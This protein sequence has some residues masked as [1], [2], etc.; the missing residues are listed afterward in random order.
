MKGRAHRFLKSFQHHTS[1]N[2]NRYPKYRLSP[3]AA[4]HAKTIQIL[5]IDN[6]WLAPKNPNYSKTFYVGSKVEL[7]S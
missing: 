6:S 7:Y 4:A 1:F 3:E 5:R 2:N